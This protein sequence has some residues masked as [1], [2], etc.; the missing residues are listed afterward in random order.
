MLLQLIKRLVH[1]IVRKNDLVQKAPEQFECCCND[2]KIY[3]KE[4]SGEFVQ[5]IRYM[6]KEEVVPQ[7]KTLALMN[8]LFQ[9]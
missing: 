9:V 1:N 3:A 5:I 6:S 7:Q 4:R 2:T 8:K